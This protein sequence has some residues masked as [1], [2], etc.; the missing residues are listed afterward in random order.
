LV[1]ELV[2]EPGLVVQLASVLSELGLGLGQALVAVEALE[3]VQEAVP[4]GV[5]LA[6]LVVPVSKMVYLDQTGVQVE[7]VLHREELALV[8]GMGRELGQER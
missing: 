2:L 3:P 8:V 7:L 5:W 1:L 6:L 4:V